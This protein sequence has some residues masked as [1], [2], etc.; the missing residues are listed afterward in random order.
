M[1]KTLRLNVAKINFWNLWLKVTFIKTVEN[2]YVI[3]YA[4][5]NLV[6]MT[7]CEYVRKEKHK[8]KVIKVEKD[9][10]IL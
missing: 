8:L 10:F 2:S 3:N 4:F 5:D 6:K 7:M 9:I 1:K